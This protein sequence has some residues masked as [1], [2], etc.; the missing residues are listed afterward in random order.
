MAKPRPV[1]QRDTQDAEKWVLKRSGERRG[2]WGQRSRKAKTQ[3][4]PGLDP[5]V[6][7]RD[8]RG[9]LQGKGARLSKPQA[10]P[11]AGVT[12]LIVAMKPGNAGGAKGGRSE[13]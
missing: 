6:K 13:E 3:P 9:S 11:R 5:G 12:A 2:G 4:A 1:S 10:R 7:R 8:L